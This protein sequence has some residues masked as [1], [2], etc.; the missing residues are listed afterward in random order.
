MLS[1]GTSLGTSSFFGGERCNSQGCHGR[2]ATT[3]EDASLAKKRRIEFNVFILC[4][5]CGPEA[6]FCIQ[7]ISA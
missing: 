6:M 5:T 3:E 4:M 1:E 2:N 7:H